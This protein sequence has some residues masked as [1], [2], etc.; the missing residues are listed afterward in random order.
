MCMNQENKK[1]RIAI[2]GHTRG[3]GKAIVTYT[4]KRFTS[5]WIEQVAMVTTYNVDQERIML[6]M[7]DCDLIVLNAM[8]GRGTTD[9]VEKD[10]WTVS[11]RDTRR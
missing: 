5:R 11:F 10:I 9:P 8:S 2:I 3:I 4:Q 6:K 1:N 7:E